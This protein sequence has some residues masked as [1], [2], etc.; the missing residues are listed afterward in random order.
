MAL[1]PDKPHIRPEWR[2]VGY[3]ALIERF[4]IKALPHY[5]RSFIG[6]TRQTHVEPDQVTEVYPRSYALGDSL[7]EQLEFALKYEGVNLEILALL[8][9][10]IDPEELT[11]YIRS[12]LT[13]KNAR[14]LWYLYEFL[15][16]RRLDIEDLKR[17]N[18]VPLLDDKRYFTSNVPYR[19]SR[20]RIIDNL[21]GYRDFCP[22]IRR[23]SA[24]EQ[25]IAERLDKR[26]KEIFQ[27]FPDDILRRALDYLYFKETKS[28][29][30]IE[31]ATPDQK[32]I[33]RFVDLLKSVETE[34]FLD[35]GALL[36]LQHEIVDERFYNTDYRTDQNFVGAS[37]R[38][39][40]Q[41]IYYV[42]PRPENVPS[43]MKGLLQ[44]GAR[45]LADLNSFTNPSRRRAF[46]HYLPL[47]EL[48]WEGILSRAQF[49][50]AWPVF[51]AA[52]ISFGFVFIHPFEDGNGRIHR[53][54][55]HH[56]L[57]Q[58]EFTP[59]GVIFPV[60]AVML[61]HR[62]KYDAL[63]ETFSKPL[64]ELID[65]ELD[66]DGVMTVKGET[67]VHYRYP[68]MT[69]F[70]EGLFDFI[71]EAIEKDLPEELRFIVA[72]D[73][74]RRG[75]QEVVDMPDRLIDLFIRLCQQNHGRLSD[76]KRASHFA[77]LTDDEIARMEACL[78]GIPGDAF[79]DQASAPESET[80]F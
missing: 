71:R 44:A 60:S 80:G 12:K 35:K 1:Q 11:R 7:S 21:L 75:I 63:L 43:L 14:R 53:F 15:T 66:D 38:Y 37:G 72:F 41:R 24:L 23:A 18:Y 67:A 13:G 51:F 45:M 70:C 48:D 27:P 6:G 65:Y 28:S 40:R 49:N 58:G 62:A 26:C 64:M 34:R 77:M 50:L 36:A 29:Y 73:K 39:N 17:G 52:A 59:P 32:R 76:A 68:D 2:S 57:A 42:S 69:R 61:R 79:D 25:A 30:A 4:S 8:F 74:A 33:S 9:E 19:R 46:D 16:G 22:M 54:L 47:E 31:R 3:S 55:I 20:Y 56:I 78:Q 5:C 10:K